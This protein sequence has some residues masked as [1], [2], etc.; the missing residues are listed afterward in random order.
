MRS[1]HRS[2]IAP[3]PDRRYR[4]SRI[5]QVRFAPFR[6]DSEIFPGRLIPVLGQAV[7]E[8]A[9]FVNGFAVPVRTL[10]RR[11]G[12]CA[13]PV[14]AKGALW[15]AWRKSRQRRACVVARCCCAPA[16]SR[17]SLHS[18]RWP[19]RSLGRSIDRRRRR[20]LDRRSPAGTMPVRCQASAVGFLSRRIVSQGRSMVGCLEFCRSSSRSTTMCSTSGSRLRRVRVRARHVPMRRLSVLAPA[21]RRCREFCGLGTLKGYWSPEMLLLPRTGRA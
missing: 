3:L 11:K 9:C 1:S 12:R 21:C 15:F 4:L 7:N 20:S 18:L 8:S 6:I 13:S 16:Q 5:I 17:L 2:I 10:S 19:F 14:G